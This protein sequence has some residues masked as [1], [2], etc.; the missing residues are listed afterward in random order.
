MAQ[1]TNHLVPDRSGWV[2]IRVAEGQHEHRRVVGDGAGGQVA[3]PEGGLRSSK[4]LAT[5]QLA[6]RQ[7]AVGHALQVKLLAPSN[8]HPEQAPEDGGRRAGVDG[9]VGGEQAAHCLRCQRP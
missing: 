2:G 5:A 1:R 3:G 9:G 6:Q 8:D 4:F 7:K